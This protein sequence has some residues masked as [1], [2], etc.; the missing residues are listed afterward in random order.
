MPFLLQNA[1]DYI[2]CE[3]FVNVDHAQKARSGSEVFLQQNILENH[4]E[5][6]PTYG[7]EYQVC[8]QRLSEEC[9]LS[10]RALQ[11]TPTPLERRYMTPLTGELMPLLAAVGRR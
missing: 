8:P 2:V 11:V 1:F 6:P 9:A 3:A 4:V 10:R 5:Q 7:T